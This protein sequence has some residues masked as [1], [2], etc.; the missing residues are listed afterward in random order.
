MTSARRPSATLAVS[1]VGAL[2]L[3]AGCA[4]TTEGEATDAG[5]SSTAATSSAAA[6]TTEEGGDLLDGLLPAEAFGADTQ[7]VTLTVEELRQAGGG[8]ATGL[9]EGTTITP[10]EC[11]ELVSG[12]Q[13]DVTEADDVVAQTATGPASI[14]VEVLAEDE[15][16]AATPLDFDQLLSQCAA[17]SATAPDGSRIDLAFAALEVPDLG[18]ESGG[19]SITTSVSAPDGT[20]L[21]VP[22]YLA[23]FVDGSRVLMMQQTGDG[24]TPLD[25]AAFTALVEQ[26]AEAAAA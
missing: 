20:Q 1:G 10:P 6:E 26:A 13:P 17:V 3:L 22:G 24:I 23:V 18:D 21:A 7:V 5:A 11:A 4:G 19:L 8:G 12:S 16:L 14:T 9:G 25:P 2:L 15:E